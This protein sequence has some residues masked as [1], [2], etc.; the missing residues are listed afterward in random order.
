MLLRDGSRLEILL[1][2]DV[3]NCCEPVYST[4]HWRC[5]TEQF[6]TVQNNSKVWKWFEAT[7]LQLSA[8][9]HKSSRSIDKRLIQVVKFLRTDWNSHQSEDFILQVNV[10]SVN[11]TKHCRFPLEDFV[12]TSQPFRLNGWIYVVLSPWKNCINEA[13]R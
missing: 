8:F 2:N 4:P 3:Y 10:L 1:W 7:C 6:C 12:V 5:L 13:F 11:D 9:L